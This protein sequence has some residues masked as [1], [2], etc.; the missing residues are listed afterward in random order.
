MKY[1]GKC[2][3]ITIKWLR[4]ISLYRKEYADYLCSEFPA[5]TKFWKLEKRIKRDKKNPGVLIE[6][7][8]SDMLRDIT[9]LIRRNLL[10]PPDI[11]CN[12][13]EAVDKL[14]ELLRTKRP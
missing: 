13:T 3:A 2:W 10:I 7:S 5:F 9:R 11:V 6:L 12:K 4:R 8:K 1:K 14:M